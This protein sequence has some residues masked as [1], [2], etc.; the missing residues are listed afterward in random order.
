MVISSIVVWMQTSG[1]ERH[2]VKNAPPP[3]VALGP[4]LVA[5]VLLVSGCS[6]AKPQ[7]RSTPNSSVTITKNWQDFFSGATSAP[8]KVALLENG[9]AFSAIITGQSASPLAKSARATVSKVSD[10]TKTTARVRYDVSLGGATALKGQIGEA[11]YQ[12]GTWKVSDS[13]FCNLLSL[14]GVKAPSCTTT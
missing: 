6:S 8:G 2:R 9:S 4:V 7:S 12:G 11:V 10:V 5:L 14:E 1:D 3:L 13:S